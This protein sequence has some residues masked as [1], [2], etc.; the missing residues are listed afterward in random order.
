MDYE[1]ISHHIN[2]EAVM[3]SDVNLG[4]QCILI[5]GFKTQKDNVIDFELAK[6]MK[7]QINHK[8]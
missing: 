1:H 2:D 3:L 5:E 7:R 4:A 6:E 8:R